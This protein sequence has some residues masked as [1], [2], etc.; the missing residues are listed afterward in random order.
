MESEIRDELRR[1]IETAETPVLETVACCS[2][3]VRTR[4]DGRRRIPLLQA[5]YAVVGTYS[6]QSGPD[7]YIA[8]S[9]RRR[10]QGDS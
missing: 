3:V 10:A 1:F 2:E 9:R 6:V 8:K 5:A 4:I 7:G